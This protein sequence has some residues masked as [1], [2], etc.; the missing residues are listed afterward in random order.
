MSEKCQGKM[1]TLLQ[2]ANT[3]QLIK[4]TCHNA[5]PG[6]AISKINYALKTF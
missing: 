1:M 6:I 2:P 4:Q 3:K 5:F